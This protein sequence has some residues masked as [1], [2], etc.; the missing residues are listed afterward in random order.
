MKITRRTALRASLFLGT[1]WLIGSQKKLN[2]KGENKISNIKRTVLIIGAGMAGI[3]AAQ[4]LQNNGYEVTILEGRNRSGGRIL[5]QR[6]ED[7]SIDLG[8]A[9]IHGDAPNN[10]L[11]ALASKYNIGTSATDWD[12]TW[13]YQAGKGVIEDSDYDKIEQKAGQLI[14]KIHELQLNAETKDSMK[15]TIQ[16]LLNSLHGSKTLKEGVRWWISS[17]IE[18]V[19]AANYKDL[20]LQFWNEDEEFEGQDLLLTNGYGNLI[21]K[22]SEE[23]DIQYNHEVNRITYTEAGIRVSG[24]WGN[25]TADKVIVTVPL[26]VLKKNRIQFIPE[27]PARK[28]ESIRRLEMGLLNKIVLTFQKAFWPK[29]AHRLGLLGADTLERIEYYPMPPGGK[30]AILVGIVYGDFARS[31]ERLSKEK[32]ISIVIN[33]LQKMFPEVSE[34]DIDEILITG[35]HSDPMSEGSYLYIPPNASFNDCKILGEP[36]ENSLFFAGE[37]TH[38]LYLGTVHGAYLSGIRSAKEVQASTNKS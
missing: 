7:T 2:A 25:A 35:W 31:I 37:A 6:F 36:V 22:L 38:P 26:G 34:S 30:S 4:E 17:E 23:M 32:V 8:A 24:P 14:K 11:M 21:D 13:L 1:P 5:T 12:E 33:Q 20:S 15:S 18:G 10:P 27:L 19:S 29:E 3:A 9:W 16:K 28:K